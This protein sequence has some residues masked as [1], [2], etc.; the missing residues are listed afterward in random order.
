MRWR[1]WTRGRCIGGRLGG[2]GRA[3]YDPDV[4][5]AVLIYAYACGVRS[6]RQIERLCHQDVAFMVISGLQ[7][8]DHVTV[9]RFRKANDA[10]MADLFGQ[11]LRL[12]G[13]AGM[14]ALGHVAI[15]GTKI[16][17]N[18]SKAQSRDADGLRAVARRLLDEAAA[19]DAE[20][21]ARF[22]S[23]R[24][25]ELPEELRDPDSR[26]RLIEEL[27]K[28]A[29]A[30]PDPHRR[31]ARVGKAAKAGRALALADEAGEADAARD[32]R[33]RGGPRARLEKAEAR[34][35]ALRAQ[36]EARA[37]DRA[38]R[39]AEAAARGTS[40]PGTRPVPVDDQAE[41]RRTA[42]K[43]D[44]DRQRLNKA[45]PKRG[46]Q[47]VHRNLTDPDSR[48]MPVPGG[49]F[50]QGY[51]AQLAVSAD[52]LI[53]A[54]DVVDTPS[55][56]TQL[57]PMLAHLDEAVALL[58]ES[59]NNPNLA[60]GTALFDAGYYNNHNLQTPGPNRLIALGK[61]ARTAGER[62][63]S[64]PPAADAPA[65]DHMAWRLST[66]EGR[67]LYKKRG[68]TVEP[69]NGIT[70]DRRGLRRFSRRGHTAAKAELTL[71]SLTTNLLR[72]FTTHPTALAH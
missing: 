38:R 9:S 48:F 56:E 66:P 70:K 28:Q 49:A 4:L 63:P 64:T 7:R 29:S 17:A 13:R 11:V 16:A 60:V 57:E 41:I 1:R 36:A 31:Q 22:G 14:G 8:P 6:S 43:V 45:Q 25:D 62:P 65:R 69:L 10:V 61:R 21:D 2:A 24:G 55:D 67:A 32:Q 12:C 27:A 3:P 39:E 44:R 72:L 35:A 50:I 37:V 71:A 53:V 59:N 58:R 26:R 42:A 20:E 19:V 54:V 68:A 40:L 30:D 18:A 34:L 23:A 5:L 47:R 33:A 52:H 15:D 51:N 46:S